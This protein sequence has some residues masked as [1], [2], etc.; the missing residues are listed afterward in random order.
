MTGDT[1]VHP[2]MCGSESDLAVQFEVKKVHYPNSIH[3]F[4]PG[5]VG[6]L[7]RKQSIWEYFGLRYAGCAVIPPNESVVKAYVYLLGSLFSGSSG[8]TTRT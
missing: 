6:A 8:G 7:R 1:L 4:Q 5:V 3:L 2:N